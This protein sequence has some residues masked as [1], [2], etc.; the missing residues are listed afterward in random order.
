MTSCLARSVSYPKLSSTYDFCSFKRENRRTFGN[1]L[2]AAGMTQHTVDM[3]ADV[4]HYSTLLPL[5]RLVALCRSLLN[6]ELRAESCEFAYLLYFAVATPASIL[7]CSFHSYPQVISVHVLHFK[8]GLSFCILC[9]MENPIE[10]DSNIGFCF[11]M[12]HM[13]YKKL[14]SS[15]T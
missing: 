9:K 3:D 6:F 5:S 14:I 8:F 4:N 13:P 2:K 10:E 1:I 11:A 15:L 12:G 7:F